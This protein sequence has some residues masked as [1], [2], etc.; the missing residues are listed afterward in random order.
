M[1][2]VVRGVLDFPGGEY[3]LCARCLGPDA[4]KPVRSPELVAEVLRH[5]AEIRSTGS[6]QRSGSGDPQR[7]KKAR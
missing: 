2:G 5:I 3:A 4:V 1:L 7:R 6:I